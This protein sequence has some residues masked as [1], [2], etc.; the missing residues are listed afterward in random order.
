VQVIPRS[1]D[2][3]KYGVGRWEIVY[4][5]RAYMR[6]HP[7]R[8]TPSRLCMGGGDVSRLVEGYMARRC[9]VLYGSEPHGP[10]TMHSM[11]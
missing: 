11:F 2:Q 7:C 10:E 3:D 8:S 4:G 1:I 9:S 6:D 5:F